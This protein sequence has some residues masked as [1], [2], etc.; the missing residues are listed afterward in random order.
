MISDSELERE[1]V[2]GYGVLS[3]MH[4]ENARQETLWEEESRQPEAWRLPV[5]QPASEECDPSEK[6]FKP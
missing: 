1:R 2:N 6:V 3:G 4:L 5:S